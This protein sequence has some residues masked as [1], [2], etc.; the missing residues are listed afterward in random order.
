MVW[1]VLASVFDGRMIGELFAAAVVK[2][3]ALYTIGRVCSHAE[4]ICPG[5]Y[6][7]F[8]IL[9]LRLLRGL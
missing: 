7:S 6:V 2:K 9:H 1:Q 4:Y 3:I 8:L 5:F